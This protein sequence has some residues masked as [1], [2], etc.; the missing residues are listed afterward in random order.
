MSTEQTTI[1]AEQKPVNNNKRVFIGNLADTTKE[2]ELLTLFEAF[3]KVVNAKIVPNKQ[4]SAFG[5]VEMENEEKAN[6]AIAQLN[7]STFGSQTID[8]EIAKTRVKK[9]RKV[10]RPRRQG[11]N[12]NTAGSTTTT[13]GTS[14]TTGSTSPS[15]N[16]QKPKR[17]ST[18]RTDK[19][20][21]TATSTSNG[22]NSPTTGDA[23]A[24]TAPTKPKGRLV[25]SRPQSSTPVEKK[26]QSTTTL[27]ITNLPFSCDDAQLLDIFKEHK[28]KSAHVITNKYNNRSKGFGFVEF[29]DAAQQQQALALNKSTVKSN[30]KDREIFVKVAY[31]VDIKTT[32][33]EATTATPPTTS[34]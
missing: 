7:K 33:T 4:G 26:E 6:Q 28:P 34:A 12:N 27:F 13:T 32:S 1:Q 29:E 30:D 10:S 31:V 14:T 16:G 23:T 18:R 5:F 22:T 2:E 15:T 3:G 20:T 19:P 9:P 11:N 25:R 8:V 17:R 24:T 21:T